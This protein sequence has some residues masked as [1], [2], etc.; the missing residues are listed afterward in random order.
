[1]VMDPLGNIPMFISALKDVPLERKR[2]V[3][4]R[5][6]LVVPGTLCSKKR[7]PWE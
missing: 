1:M 3:L 6:L 7:E 5:E 2:V 4:V